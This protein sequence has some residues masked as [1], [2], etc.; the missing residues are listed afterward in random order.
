MKKKEVIRK[1][2]RSIFRPTNFGQKASDKITIWIG[3]WPFIILFVLLLIIW[4]VAIILLSKDTL[5]ID[6][7][8]IL[9]LF[10]SCV[11]AIQAPIILMSQ[12]RSSQK[13]RKRMEYDYQ[14]DRR[15][16]KEIKKIKIQLDRIESKLNQRKY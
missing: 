7:F 14:V 10:L 4:I 8:L 9:N 13:D 2:V 11:A 1:N 6:H 3:S 16:E 12:N 5:D 15:T